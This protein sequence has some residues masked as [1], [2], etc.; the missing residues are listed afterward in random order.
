MSRERGAF[1]RKREELR[2]GGGGV[3]E[4]EGRGLRGGRTKLVEIVKKQIAVKKENR[5]E[6]GKNGHRSAGC[7]ARAV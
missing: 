4:G 5:N 7:C 3:A 6:N 2:R 1:R